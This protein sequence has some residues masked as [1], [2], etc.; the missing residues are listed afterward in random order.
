MRI[1]FLR[2]AYSWKILQKI[3]K[4]DENT[5]EQHVLRNQFTLDFR[6]ERWIFN[7]LVMSL[8]RLIFLWLGV[9]RLLTMW[10]ISYKSHINWTCSCHSDVM[11]KIYRSESDQS[12]MLW[13][14]H[15]LSLHFREE[16]SKILWQIKQFFSHSEN[17]AA[18]GRRGYYQFIYR[19]RYNKFQFNWFR[20]ALSWIEWAAGALLH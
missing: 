20:S 19:E 8:M 5:C 11:R 17:F 18:R 3:V 10:L 1:R 2:F 6:Q 14:V 9:I 15:L 12:G 13:F 7:N 4:F 16:G